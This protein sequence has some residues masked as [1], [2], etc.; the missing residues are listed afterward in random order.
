MPESWDKAH[1]H[2]CSLRVALCF[3]AELPS[4]VWGG[5]MP[6]LLTP[7]LLG[8][9]RSSVRRW[10][11]PPG[12]LGTQQRGAATAADSWLKPTG[13]GLVVFS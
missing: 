8:E 9:H 4:C 3:P 13:S 6:L 11:T 2:H 5:A 10:L 12:V 7:P 1:G